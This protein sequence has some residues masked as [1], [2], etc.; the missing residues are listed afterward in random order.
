MNLSNIAILEIKN[1]DYRF[2]I[3]KH[4]ASKLLQN[5]NLAE[6]S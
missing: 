1:T 6:K 3:T 2:G 4:E 5:T